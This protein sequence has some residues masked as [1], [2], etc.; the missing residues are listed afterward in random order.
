MSV[1]GARYVCIYTNEQAHAVSRKA[2]FKL[3]KHG[4]YNSYENVCRQCI[5]SGRCFSPTI[6]N[7]TSICQRKNAKKYF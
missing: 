6:M 3:H 4:Y 5:L 7:W 1:K 2:A